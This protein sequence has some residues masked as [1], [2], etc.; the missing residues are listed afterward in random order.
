MDRGNTIVIIII[1][2]LVVAAAVF[3]TD[4]G[5]SHRAVSI[6]ICELAC[7]NVTSSGYR[8]GSFCISQ[9]ISFGYSC[10]LSPVINQS[11]CTTSPTVYVNS[12]C[13]LVGVK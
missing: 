7:Q 3:Y 11:I 12:G 2:L 4:T 1:V 5:Q 13:Q 10:A 9:N 6:G 8:G